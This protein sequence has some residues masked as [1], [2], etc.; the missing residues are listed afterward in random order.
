MK[1]PSESQAEPSLLARLADFSHGI[2]LADIPAE[3]RK[4][5]RL[6]ILDTIGCIA[7]GAALSDSQ[8]LLRAES[9]RGGPAEATVLGSRT[10]L[11]IEAA[12]RVNGYMGD[13]FELND[14]IGGHASIATTSRYANANLKLK[15]E[16]LESFW[17]HAGL[18][19]PHI[20]PWRPRKS[21]LNF[22][23]SV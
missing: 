12:T 2:R 10:R 6:N 21:L 16:A 7:S 18:G 4:Q 11:P 8:L 14:L 3:V 15:S 19:T 5:A 23:S 9:A 20:P 22:L 17:E 13:V 1:T